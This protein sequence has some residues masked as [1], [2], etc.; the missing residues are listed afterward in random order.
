[1]A[2][3]DYYQEQED[4]P[5]KQSKEITDDLICPITL[6]L[7]FDPV[8]AED[9]RVYDIMIVNRSVQVHFAFILF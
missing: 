9:G 1:M 2:D 8:I 5:P 3:T 6:D 7:P 4:S